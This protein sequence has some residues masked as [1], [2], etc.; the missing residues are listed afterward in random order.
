MVWRGKQY[1]RG[2]RLFTRRLIV[3]RAQLEDLYKPKTGIRFMRQAFT[4]PMNPTDGSWRLIYVG[5]NGQLIGSLKNRTVNA[6][7]VATL[8]QFG[9]AA[10]SSGFGS[11][12]GSQ[13]SF[14]NSSFGNSSF[15]NSNSIR[16]S[17]TL[18]LVETLPSGV[19]HPSVGIVLSALVAMALKTP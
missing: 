9:S 3:S 5:P 7:G 8:P 14:G 15:G 1:V 11:Q 13:S 18:R 16:P 17:A 6:G 19:I 12:A 4:D 2:I 10:S